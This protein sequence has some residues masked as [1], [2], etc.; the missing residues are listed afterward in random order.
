MIDRATRTSSP[1]SRR[2]ARWPPRPSTRWA[3][4]TSGAAPGPEL[5]LVDKLGGLTI[6]SAAA[7]AKLGEDYKVWF[8]EKEQSLKE[9]LMAG[10]VGPRD[11]GR[12]GLRLH[13]RAGAGAGRGRRSRHPPGRR[14]RGRPPLRLERPARDLRP[15]LLRG[16]V[17]P[18]S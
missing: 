14:G 10:L 2:R 17:A 9:K 8:I 3:A 7:K 15:L 5:G 13:P 11:P 4:A 6:A 18:A 12:R 16:E 1:A